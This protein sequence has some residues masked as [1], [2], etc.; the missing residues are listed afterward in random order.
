MT[1]TIPRDLLSDLPGAAPRFHRMWVGAWLLA[2]DRRLSRSECRDVLARA[3]KLWPSQQLDRV[4]RL[5][6]LS[7]LLELE[8]LGVV[9][10]IVGDLSGGFRIEVAERWSAVA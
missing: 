10:G 9:T 7:I 2:G 6:V 8:K 1:V 5:S 4:G 3:A